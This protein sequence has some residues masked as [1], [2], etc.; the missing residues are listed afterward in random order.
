MREFFGMTLPKEDQLP[1]LVLGGM[2]SAAF[3]WLDAV[4][5]VPYGRDVPHALRAVSVEGSA[6]AT[7]FA[8]IVPG[9]FYLFRFRDIPSVAA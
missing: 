5:L 6:I 1:A 3:Y 8:V 2:A 7:A 9:L 4:T